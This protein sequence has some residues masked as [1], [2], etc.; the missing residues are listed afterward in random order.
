MGEITVVVDVSGQHA[1]LDVVE[2]LARIQLEARRRGCRIRL[3][4]PS[5]EL[6]ELLA[7]VGLAQ[8][9]REAGREPELGE[10]M[11]IDEARDLG[12]LPA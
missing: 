10:E 11:G 2:V 1:A 5:P 6:L 4:H 3:Q 8:L 12:D 7:L 9:L